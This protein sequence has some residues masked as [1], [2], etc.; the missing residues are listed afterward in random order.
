M[1]LRMLEGIGTDD[2]IRERGRHYQSSF[3]ALLA[4]IED[5]IFTCMQ[6][7][8]NHLNVCHGKGDP[9]V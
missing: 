5:H 3:F 1:N 4:H 9:R 8:L 6:K 7:E 2:A